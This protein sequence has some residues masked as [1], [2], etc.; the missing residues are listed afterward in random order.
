V[1][2]I[3]TTY[4]NSKK[5]YTLPTNCIYVLHVT[6]KTVIS[7]NSIK[8]LVSVRQ[9]QHVSDEEPNICIC[10]RACVRACVCV[11]L[12]NFRLFTG[13]K[14]HMSNGKIWVLFRA[15]TNWR[16]IND[17]FLVL[18]QRICSPKGC[19]KIWLLTANVLLQSWYT[20]TRSTDFLLLSDATKFDLLGVPETLFP[21][22]THSS[23]SGWNYTTLT[24]TIS[25]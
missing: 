13:L 20:V 1:V 3:C 8:W 5:P 22:A 12:M 14:H 25:D 17:E 19:C 15:G 18:K 23:V 24:E 2:T 11:I 9:M 7:I 21:L 10:A 4:F 6:F 16:T